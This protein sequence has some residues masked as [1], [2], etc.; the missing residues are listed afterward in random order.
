[1]EHKSINN[2][3]DSIDYTIVDN[4]SQ[5]VGIANLETIRKYLFDEKGGEYNHVDMFI[6]L[7]L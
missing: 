5:F 6:Y 3:L 7:I 2:V 4:N 1:M